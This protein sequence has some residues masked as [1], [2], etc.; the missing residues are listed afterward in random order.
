MLKIGDLEIKN[1]CIIGPMAGVSDKAFRQ[2]QSEVSGA[3]IVWT[4][5]VNARA[6]YYNDKKTMRMLET[7]KGENPIAYQLFGDDPK[8]M[9]KAAEILSEKCDVLDI[10]MGCPA[11]KIVKAGGGSDLLKD[12]D[13]AKEVIKSVIE[14]SKVPVTLKMRLGWDNENINCLEVAKMAEECGVKMITIHGRTRSQYYT[15]QAR[16][17]EIKEVKEN[18]KI[19]VIVN[20][21]ITSAEKAFEVLEYTK[22]DG[23]MISRGALGKPYKVKNIVESLEKGQ[24]I[25]EEEITVQ[26]II[27]LV[28]THFD[29]MKEDM[30]E[31]VAS[32]EIRKHVIW[33]SSGIPN[34]KNV[35][36]HVQ[37][38]VD[39]KT[40]LE[41]LQIMA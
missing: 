24:V 1:N 22:C 31:E 40:L 7:Y 4:E 10:N 16:Y 27:D 9:G 38:I 19:P 39:R 25:P 14:N 13:K 35:R 34:G 6:V 23:V 28:V 18:L 26:K 37:K 5:M 12:I 30:G 32:K 2:I 33:Y 41:V 3:G 29:I 8:Y 36:I 15:G 21:D 20:G 11:P 17:N